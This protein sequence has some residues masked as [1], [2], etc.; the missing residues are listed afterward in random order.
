MIVLPYN[1]KCRVCMKFF[2]RDDSR[3]STS[4]DFLSSFSRQCK[5]CYALKNQSVIKKILFCKITIKNFHAR[6]RYSRLCLISQKVSLTTQVRPQSPQRGLIQHSTQQ[7]LEQRHQQMSEQKGT[8][9][10]LWRQNLRPKQRVKLTR[11]RR[12]SIAELWGWSYFS[13]G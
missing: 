7:R 2:S 13:L 5:P 3:C 9:T 6:A 11:K 4:V 10:Q 8:Q 1:L 12:Q